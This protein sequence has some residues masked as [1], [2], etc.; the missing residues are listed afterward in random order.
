IP[1]GMSGDC[2]VR[3]NLDGRLRAI[4]YGRPCAVHVDPMEKKPLYHFRPGTR[5]FSLATAGCNLHCKNC[6]NWEIA[7]ANPDEVESQTLEPADV[8]E[9]A[10][11][12]S[13]PSIAYTYTEPLVYYEYVLDTATR[14]RESQ[15]A[16][17]VISAGYV[18]PEPLKRLARVID[19]FKIDL[20]SM[21]D[22][23]YREICSATLKPVLDALLVIK[24]AGVWLEVVNLI[25]PTLSDDLAMIRRM[26]KWIARNL[27]EST[28]L[29]FSRFYPQY[30]LQNLPPTP[31]ET[32]LAA[33]KEA[34]DAGL[35]HVYI[36]NIT[37]A[38]G[39]TTFCAGCNR[40][41]IERV[42][43]QIIENRIENGR[44]DSCKAV[45]AGRW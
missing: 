30:Q 19:A 44:C 16:N 27:G 18:L 17:V 26:C 40:P 7:Q 6:Q 8:V 15:L 36:G 25:V 1:P 10:R 22:R 39:E 33:R 34:R 43:Y 11:R 5:I 2:R 38:D 14:A 9:A 31:A 12:T 32:L 29:H 37:V 20:K 28:P 35:K 41:L 23:F 4:T 45:V 42:G 3:V 21:D 24:E 13:C